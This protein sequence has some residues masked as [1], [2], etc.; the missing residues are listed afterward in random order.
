MKKD[1]KMLKSVSL[2]TGAMLTGSLASFAAS[3]NSESLLEYQSL[4]SGAEVRSELMDLNSPQILNSETTFKM[5]ELKCGE[6]KCGEGK[7][8]EGDKKKEDGKAKAKKSETKATE[9]KCGEGKDVKTEKKA[10]TK[11]EGKTSEAKCG[12]GKCGE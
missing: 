2:I 1:K 8:G 7:C 6:G 12:E 3:Q 11:K 9:A 10:E 4:G 5:G